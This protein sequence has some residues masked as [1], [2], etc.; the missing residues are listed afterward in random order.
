ML[1]HAKVRT[2][3]PAP[4]ARASGAGVLVILAFVVLGVSGASADTV[5]YTLDNVIMSGGGRQMSGTFSWTYDDPEEFENGVG[6][7]SFLDIPFTA[8]DHTDLN[9]EVDVGTSL[10]ITYPGNF[11]DDGVDITLFLDGA[12]TPTSGA[13]VDL[14]RS[15][16]EIGGNGFHD[17]VFI[18]GSI[19]LV[20]VDTPGDTDG[21]HDVDDADYA[22]LVA[23]FG[24]VPA[25]DSADFNN[26]GTVDLIDFSIQRANFGVGVPTPAPGFAATIPEPAT[27]AL[28]AAILPLML[29]RRRL[30]RRQ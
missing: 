5:N 16:Y 1:L 23:Q 25:A 4:M 27:T 18:S 22:N 10:E 6:V 9:A 17:G 13:P 21:D 12:L 14:D 20:V 24:G 3:E 8:H 11:H 15:K 26:D 30:R 2:A 19:S 29:R 7:F 28:L